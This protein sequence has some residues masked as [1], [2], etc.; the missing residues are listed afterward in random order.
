MTKTELVRAVRVLRAMVRVDEE[1]AKLL[2]EK[3]GEIDGR[4]I[5]DLL[6]GVT[7]SPSPEVI[8]GENKWLNEL[9][10]E[11]GVDEFC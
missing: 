8:N 5:D 6:A 2:F 3:I 10:A 1:I 9:H 7:I 4:S 11:K